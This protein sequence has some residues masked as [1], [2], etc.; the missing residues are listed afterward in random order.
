MIIE[1]KKVT[2]EDLKEVIKM[3]KFMCAHYED[4]LYFDELLKTE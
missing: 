2:L 1:M 4:L 3:H